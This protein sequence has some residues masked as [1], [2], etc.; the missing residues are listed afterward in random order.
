MMM[1]RPAAESGV[2]PGLMRRRLGRMSPIAPNISATAMK[3]RNAPGS[4]ISF[5]ISSTVMISFATPANR[6]RPASN[7]WTIHSAAVMSCFLPWRMC[8]TLAVAGLGPRRPRRAYARAR[9]GLPRR[10]L[11]DR[12]YLDG[13]HT[14]QGAAGREVDRLVEVVDVDHHVA[15]EVLAGL[16]ERAIGQEPLAVAHP[17][18]GRRRGG[19][20]RVAAKVPPLRDELFRVLHL[21][22]EGFLPLGEAPLVPGLVEVNQQHV[23]H[24]CLHL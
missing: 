10:P 24:V 13:T 12:P 23:F 15:P 21:G 2:R 9:R 17:D 4:G 14:C 8:A 7:P 18:G 11:P 3:R 20:E 19:M 22:P 6:T 16:G 5:V 1:V